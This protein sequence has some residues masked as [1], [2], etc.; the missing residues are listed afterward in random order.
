MPQSRAWACSSLTF[1]IMA[2]ASSI[3]CSLMSARISANGFAGRK[4]FTGRPFVP[5]WTARHDIQV[6]L[7]RY[8][9]ARLTSGW[10]RFAPHSISRIVDS[11]FDSRY[12]STLGKGSLES[13]FYEKIYYG[14]IIFCEIGN[15]SKFHTGIRLALY[16]NFPPSHHSP[17]TRSCLARFNSVEDFGNDPGAVLAFLGSPL[18]KNLQ[19]PAYFADF[20]RCNDDPVVTMRHERHLPVSGLPVLTGISTPRKRQT[21][22]RLFPQPPCPTRSRSRPYRR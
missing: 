2:R 17:I 19:M 6:L 15:F 20:I 3:F 14:L 5:P 18:L 12:T 1:S 4:L 16:R 22:P 10:R 13:K 21:T 9:V 11:G 7:S 8:V